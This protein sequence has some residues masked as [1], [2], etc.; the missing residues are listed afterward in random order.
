M[1]FIILDTLRIE[2]LQVSL[3]SHLGLKAVSF[4]NRKGS[5]RV[6][7]ACSRFQHQ[8]QPFEPM[9]NGLQCDISA[10]FSFSKHAAQT[11]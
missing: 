10:N 4:L 6:W 2:A 8:V 9:P 11:P 3:S 1:K 7:G 5:E